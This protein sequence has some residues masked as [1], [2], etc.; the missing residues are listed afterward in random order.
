[1]RRLGLLTLCLP[2]FLGLTR[3]FNASDNS[4]PSAA[5]GGAAPALAGAS[6]GGALNQATAGSAPVVSSGGAG[7][8]LNSAGA[9][10]SPDPLG[11]TPSSATAKFPFPQNRFST[12]CKYP[13]FHNSDVR[14]AYQWWKNDMVTADGA[15]GHLRVKRTSSG[16]HVDLDQQRR[17]AERSGE[18]GVGRHRLRHA[19]RRIHGRSDAVRRALEVR[20]AV[21]E[22]VSS[23]GLVHRGRRQQARRRRRCQR[24]RRGHG[25]RSAHG[26]SPMGRKRQPGQ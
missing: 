9:A 19:D 16:Q 12:N 15:G 14:A 4:A 18:H 26:R 7:G 11:P 2:A 20:A 8:A 1:M 3:C 10:G 5:P 22:H 17:V 24:R 6:S 25:V 23:H 21:A 13:A